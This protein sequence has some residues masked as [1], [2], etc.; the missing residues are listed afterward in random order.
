MSRRESRSSLGARQNDALFEFENC[1][2]ISQ[3]RVDQS[4]TIS[5]WHFL[6]KKKFLLANK[7]ITKYL[8]DSTIYRRLLIRDRSQTQFDTECSHRGAQCSNI[9]ALCRKPP[10]AGIRNCS[11]R[12][13]E[14]RT[15]KITPSPRR[16]GECGAPVSISNTVASL[17]VSPSHRTW[18]NI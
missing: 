8:S 16:R 14:A 15:G 4:L 3:S 12:P 13:A 9:H 11:G 5:L 1:A 6:V 2:Y 17:T 7:H 18:R 10:V